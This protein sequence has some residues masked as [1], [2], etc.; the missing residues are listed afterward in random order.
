MPNG[1]IFFVP[2]CSNCLNM[3]KD[4]VYIKNEFEPVCDSRDE[5]YAHKIQHINPWKCAE[6]G[7]EFTSVIYPASPN[8]SYNVHRTINATQTNI[9]N[10]SIHE[11]EE[12]NN[13]TNV[14][15]V[16]SGDAAEQ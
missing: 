2:V 4:E 14:D 6:C 15:P 9:I 11:S 13:A 1:S 7:C 12:S 3:I 8:M 5:V 10:K 16:Q